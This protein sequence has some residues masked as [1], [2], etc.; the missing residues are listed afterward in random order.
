MLYSIN[1]RKYLK[2]G[3][4]FIIMAIT[5][6]TAKAQNSIVD[7]ISTTTPD[8]S[9]TNTPKPAKK[10]VYDL[11]DLKIPFRS[12]M[13]N[14]SNTIGSYGGDFGFQGKDEESY[15][16]I[17]LS[18]IELTGVFRFVT[19]YRSMDK[20]YAD[21]YTSKKN[22]SFFDYP[23]VDIGTSAGVGNPILALAL[24]AKV[25]N[26]A[27]FK[28]GYAIS[29][30]FTGSPDNTTNKLFSSFSGLSFESSVRT[31][32]VLFNLKFGGLLSLRTSRL[33]FDTPKYRGNY[34]DRFVTNQYSV[35]KFE[36]M[37]SKEGAKVFNWPVVRGGIAKFTFTGLNNLYIQTM[38]GRSG[39]TIYGGIPN[40]EF[41]PA[42]SYMVRVGTPYNFGRAK[43]NF[44]LNY[45]A[46]KTNTDTVNNIKDNVDVYSMDFDSKIGKF[47]TLRTEVGSSYIQN[48][49]VA[50][51]KWGVAFIGNL[52]IDKSLLKFPLTVEYYDIGYNYGSLDG[53][54]LNS[55]TSLRSGG[56]HS[57]PTRDQTLF[58][59]AGQEVGQVANNRRG[60]S[61]SSDFQIGNLSI[62]LGY[63]ASGE[64][65][66]IHDSITF[67]HRVN[68]FS[69]SRFTQWRQGVGPYGRIKSVF[70]RT[71]ELLT[72]T[73]TVTDYKKGFNNIE[74]LAKYNF[75]LGKLKFV[76]INY[77]NFVSIQ[78]H[79]AV[80]PVF[81]NK[82]FIRTWFDDLTLMC[83]LNTKIM[84][85]AN[86]GI[87]RAWG[88]TRV[89][90]ADYTGQEIRD[91]S[92]RPTS[93]PI[94]KTIDQTGQAWGIGLGYDITNKT[95]IHIRHKWMDQKD[96]H[97]TQDVFRGTE[98]TIE[99]KMFL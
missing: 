56:V 24:T 53:E 77:S 36:S 73:D 7:S 87:E 25:K 14:R 39:Q 32:P 13:L 50:D 60:V 54:V 92:G 89:N 95:S 94:G 46:R 37:Y 61:L 64:R 52:E 67:Q 12:H 40:I 27:S 34:F 17:P 15:K 3:L 96:K 6:K 82:A 81:T 84:L 8:S 66:N 83:K 98:S 22:L 72:I 28:I 93:S 68:A 49:L 75:G 11:R 33:I 69:R 21:M 43:G 19:I 74:M 38:M 23:F 71:Y 57:D 31:T 44:A 59:N 48:P 30:S 20:A 99:L 62:E 86:Y 41:F 79:S 51:P 2:L 26:N 45:F 55:N 63:A 76:A 18:K 88:N 58:I 9:Q 90:V 35:G 97:F 16:G 47:F 10:G 5:Y 78:D 4:P 65:Q 42:I 70:A 80:V 91:V 29:H 85:L 1:V